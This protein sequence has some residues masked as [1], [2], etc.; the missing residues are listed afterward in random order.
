MMAFGRRVLFSREGDS[1]EE[2]GLMKFYRMKGKT[3]QFWNYK[4]NERFEKKKGL[5]ST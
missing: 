2:K 5:S 4:E 1:C 3:L